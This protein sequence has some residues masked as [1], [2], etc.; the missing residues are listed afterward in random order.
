MQLLDLRGEVYGHLTVVSRS[1]D[2]IF[3]SG[4]RARMWRCKCD[5]GNMI[6]VDGRNLRSGHTQ[7]CGC[8]R[9]ERKIKHGDCLSGKQPRMYRI[10]AGMRARC[11]SPN[12]VHYKEYGARG[13][14]VCEEWRDYSKFKEW[15]I[16]NGY[17]DSL[18]LDRIDVNGDYSPENCRWASWR[19]QQNNSRRNVVIE[20]GGQR[21]TLSEWAEIYGIPYKTFWYRIRS[22][23][24]FDKASSTPLRG[25][26]GRQ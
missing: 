14:S 19:T 24:S 17:E 2:H 21:H 8:I 10:W 26:R 23:W 22:G 4:Q 6:I 13:I 16:K 3:P 18:T 15:A 7:S 20:H 12:S 1:D 11:N 9:S 5:C 25:G